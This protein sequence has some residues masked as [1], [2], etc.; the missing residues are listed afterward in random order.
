[1]RRDGRGGCA[2]DGG[3]RREGVDGVDGFGPASL[4]TGHGADDGDGVEGD[5]LGRL[6]DGGGAGRDDL[7]CRGGVGA[8]GCGARGSVV[9]YLGL[10]GEK[11]ELVI[12]ILYNVDI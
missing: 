7:G 2:D 8:Q 3:G 5:A 4:G 10:S 1:M 6:D 9:Q 12:D 11:K